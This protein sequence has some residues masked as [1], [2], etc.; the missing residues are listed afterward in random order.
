MIFALSVTATLLTGTIVFMSPRYYQAN[1]TIV[2]PLDV[3]QKEASVG[4][5]G[6]MGNSMLRDIIDT[7]S[8]AGMYVEI[9]NSREVADSIIDRFRLMEAYENIEHRPDARKQLKK[10]TKIETTEEGAVKIAVTDLDPNRA[11]AVANAYVE[12]L[13]RQ[14]KRLSAGQATSKRLFLENRLKEIE[15]KFGRIE[16][17]P[18]REARVQEMLYELL[19]RECELAK[20]EEARS[21]PTIQILDAAEV[22]ELAVG[23]GTVK[24]GMLAGVVAAMLGVFLA[25]V[26]EYRQETKQNGLAKRFER[27]T[28]WRRAAARG[29]VDRPGDD[30]V[31]QAAVAGTAD[32]GD[33]VARP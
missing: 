3:L 30:G 12:G 25:F 28:R 15:Q 21:M 29:R 24:K 17:I 27:A 20:I 22:P 18:A 14:N 13:D 23:R 2:P 10:N 31:K 16:T 26:L 19:I 33:L 32:A 8:I 7:G 6:A 4:A 11:A 1:V 9:L 5:L